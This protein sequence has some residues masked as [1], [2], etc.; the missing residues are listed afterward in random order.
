MGRLYSVDMR[1]RPRGRS[2]PL[3]LTL[4]DFRQYFSREGGGSLW[5]RQAL[6]RGRVIV[7]EGD[8]E[9]TVRQAMCRPLTNRRGAGS[10]YRDGSDA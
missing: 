1:L 8:F 9:S 6:M 4:A 10:G 2:G 7:A 5:E 3:V